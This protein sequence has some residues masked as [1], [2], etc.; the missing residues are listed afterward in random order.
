MNAHRFNEVGTCS[1]LGILPGCAFDTN[2]LHPSKRA[3]YSHACTWLE[4][5]SP[6]PFYRID[7]SIAPPPRVRTQHF[8]GEP[9]CGRSVAACWCAR[10]SAE[11]CVGTPYRLRNIRYAQYLRVVRKYWQCSWLTRRN[12]LRS[13]NTCSPSAANWKRTEK[14]T[15]CAEPARRGAVFW[16]AAKT[17]TLAIIRAS[18]QQ[19]AEAEWTLAVWITCA[20]HLSLN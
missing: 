2:A 3:P 4:L 9:V 8:R 16:S 10:Q 5:W 12:P 20:A 7:G 6:P 19:T 14:M 18:I 17:P 15:V 1:R 11:S 13:Y